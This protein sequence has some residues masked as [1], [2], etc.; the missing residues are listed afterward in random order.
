MEDL[1]LAMDLIGDIHL[2][3]LAVVVMCIPAYFFYA[4]ALFG[5]W[6]RFFQAVQYM[7]TPN[8]WSMIR[9]EGVEDRWESMKFIL[10][11]ALCIGTVY[12]VYVHLIPLISPSFA[13]YLSEL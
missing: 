8:W 10:L 13:E 2:G 9:G 5:S 6:E 12:E 4:W 11:I 7:A 3:W 1:R